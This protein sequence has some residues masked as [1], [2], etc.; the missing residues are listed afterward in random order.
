MKKKIVQFEIND[1][2]DLT[3]EELEEKLMSLTLRYVC[4]KGE[5]KEYSSS[6]E[7]VTTMIEIIDIS[8]ILSKREEEKEKTIEENK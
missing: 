6:R 1:Y 2:S 3:N 8:E 7:V 5:T 4:Q